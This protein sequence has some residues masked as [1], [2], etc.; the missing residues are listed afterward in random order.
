[1]SRRMK[2][3]SVLT[4]LLLASPAAAMDSPVTAPRAAWPPAELTAADAA[5]PVAA[6]GSLRAASDSNRTAPRR[7]NVATWPVYVRWDMEDGSLLRVY[8]PLSV[9]WRSSQ[10]HSGY[11]LFPTTG[12]RWHASGRS[13]YR[14]A[15]PLADFVRDPALGLKRLNLAGPLLGFERMSNDRLNLLRIAPV[16]SSLRAASGRRQFEIAPLVYRL[17]DP[18]LRT[19]VV[20]FGFVPLLGGH[21]ASLYRSWSSPVRH[22]WNAALFFAGEE[23]GGSRELWA[24][25]YYSL[26][27]SIGRGAPVHSRSLLPLF[28]S[29]SSA[30][31]RWWDAAFVLGAGRGPEHSWLSIPPYFAY[32]RFPAPDSSARWRSVLPVFASWQSRDSKWWNV[33]A[34]YSAGHSSRAEWLSVP[35]YFSVTHRRSP[36]NVSR[37]QTLLPLYARWRSP[38]H[39]LAVALPSLWRYRSPGMSA[40]GAWP[41]YAWFRR[42][43]GDS[44][45]RSGGSVAWPL[46]SWGHGTGYSALGLLP[47]YYRLE[48]GETRTTLAPPLFMSQQRPGLDFRVLAPLYVRRWTGTDSLE[49]FTLFY[50]RR[51]GGTRATGIYPW[52]E[53][54]RSAGVRREYFIPY[55]YHRRDQVGERR[56]VFPAWADWRT[57]GTGERTRMLGPLV[58]TNGPGAHGFGVVPVYYTGWGPSGTASLLGP[59]YWSRGTSGNRRV[60]AF[61]LA[62]YSRDRAA[63][64]LH[65]FPLGGYGHRVDGRSQLYVLWPLYT[66]Q[67]HADGTRLSSLLLWLGRDSRRGERRRAWLQ[68]LVY[69]DRTSAES[70]YLALLGGVLASYERNGRERT[71]KVLMLPLRKWS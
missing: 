42:T 22:G 57:A 53:A 62:W 46:V 3:Y 32:D 6:A 52:Y 8:G 38:Q 58:V 68:P 15:W 67:V 14:L 35:P 63:T 18:L 30:D 10:E 44:L 1:M 39:E 49:A 20:E 59:L 41:A 11:L 37:F 55:Y 40:S 45:E 51:G 65:V 12:A 25:L 19:H 17:D 61:P 70:S 33:A 28:A 5:L 24:P 31:S 54:M 23:G 4:A 71:L 21:G 36:E 13:E 16:F 50:R 43:R 26:D 48:D 66:R 47:F 69:Y 60:V 27:R 29:W 56:F 9:A 64:E 34:V 2:M 7:H